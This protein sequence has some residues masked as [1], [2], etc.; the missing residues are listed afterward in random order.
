MNIL[1]INGSPKGDKS[2]SLRLANAFIKGLCEEK[3]RVK[4]STE[5]EQLDVAKLHIEG[6]KGCFACWKATP[7]KCCIK[8]D[9][10][11]VLQKILWADLIVYSF[12]LYYFNVPGTLK[13]LIDRQLPMVLP[14]M[15]EREDG[16][17]S[18]SHDARYDMSGKKYVL[19]STCGFYSSKGNYDSVCQMFDH[20]CGKEKYETIFCGQGELFRVKELHGRTDEYLRQVE[21]AGTE[22]ACGKIEE[23]TKSKLEEL[24]FPKEVFERMADASWGVS[25]ESGEKEA[26]SLVFTRQMAAL[27][28]P[29]SHDGK[30]R[31]LEM[32]Y[33][34]LGQTYQ[35]LMTTTGSKV[36]TDGSLKYTTR[37][38][39]PYDVWVSIAQN[40]IRGDEALMKQMYKVSGDF[41]LMINWNKYFGGEEAVEEKQ[42][43][44]SNKAKKPPVMTTM[45]LAWIS[46]WVAMSVNEQMG[47]LVTLAV[48]ACIP[49][50]MHKHEIVWF[51]KLSIAATA[52]LSI[53]VLVTENTFL[54]IILSYFLFG[55]M[56]LGSCFTKEP[57]CAAYVKY[58]YNGED[59][60]NNP[61]F[62]KTNYIIAAGWG[63]LYIAMAVWTYLLSGTSLV[64][65]VVL[66]NNIMPAFMGIFTVW[67]QKWYPAWVA[68]GKAK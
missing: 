10:T 3:K 63:I 33:T 46:F 15:S 28:N 54:G 5:V 57:V 12:P 38:E 13:N 61:I 22:Y 27:Y 45:L 16:V 36:V 59:A 42:T 26:E 20:I 39:T 58:D 48:G 60:L 51:D 34:D 2:N 14:F 66:L 11:M 50:F 53:L 23:D 7:G 4:L 65:M 37:I 21:K 67:F 64:Q 49:L 55:V 44:V 30:D 43:A 40:E 24:L 25:K 9:M 17:G 56:W 18:G 31:V 35:I 68:G 29:K 62:M 19:I 41:D 1:V 52:L 6:C 8:D 47:P 32:C